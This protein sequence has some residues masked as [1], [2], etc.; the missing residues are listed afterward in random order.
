[1]Q[2]T[3]AP[4]SSGGEFVDKTDL[5]P[6]TKWTATDANAW[7]AELLHLITEAGLIPSG[8][9]L[10]QVRKAVQALAKL[11]KVDAASEADHAD[12]ATNALE[13]SGN[14]ASSNISSY[15]DFTTSWPG[16]M[17]TAGTKGSFRIEQPVAG[18]YILYICVAT[19]T[20]R[21]VSLSTF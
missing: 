19:N 3:T 7:Q 20:W 1:M 8:A 18:T 14:A 12:E 6:G 5:T 13:C 17:S 4:G 10:E 9:D 15:L 2:A 21:K 11:V 16:S